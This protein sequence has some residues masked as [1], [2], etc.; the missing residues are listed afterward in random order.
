VCVCCSLSLSVKL[1]PLRHLPPAPDYRSVLSIKEAEERDTQKRM[2]FRVVQSP[3]THTGTN[4]FTHTLRL[5]G[6]CFWL[7]SPYTKK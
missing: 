3:R 4:A 1:P 6:A 7:G 5:F 2:E